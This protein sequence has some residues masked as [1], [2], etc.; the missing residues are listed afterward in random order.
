MYEGDSIWSQG[1]RAASQC[2]LPLGWLRPIF[3]KVFTIFDVSSTEGCHAT[4]LTFCCVV[5]LVL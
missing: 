4:P 2:E 1:G 5:S 3:V